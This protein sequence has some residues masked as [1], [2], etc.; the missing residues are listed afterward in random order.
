MHLL[1]LLLAVAVIYTAGMIPH[2]GLY[3]RGAD[4]SI[5]A[6]HISSLVVFILTIALLARV[7][8]L[9][10]AAYGL[11]AAFVWMGGLKL[12]QYRRQSGDLTPASA[13]TSPSQGAI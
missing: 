8:P 9:E 7:A 3:A 12:V 5:V 2:Y 6:T 13:T 1:W 10:A 11:I 4:R